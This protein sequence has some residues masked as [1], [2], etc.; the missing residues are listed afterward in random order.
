MCKHDS[1]IH[2][3]FRNEILQVFITTRT[4]RKWLMTRFPGYFSRLII[5]VYYV[6]TLDT[7]RYHL[8]ARLNIFVRDYVDSAFVE[9]IPGVVLKH[10]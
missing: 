7:V 2:I 8:H 10:T 6:G 4:S 5:W 9:G 1:Q 3:E